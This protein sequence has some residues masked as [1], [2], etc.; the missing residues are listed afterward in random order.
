MVR[1]PRSS[2]SY[3]GWGVVLV[4]VLVVVVEVVVLVVVVVEVVVLVV[5]VVVLLV[6]VDSGGDIVALAGTTT[7]ST[8]GLVHCLGS[9][10]A[11]ATM[12]P[13]VRTA[14]TA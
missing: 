12:P 8:I 5:E 11:V 4:E 7:V 13:P 3:Q 10:N 6:E 9:A 1:C 14:F 2:F